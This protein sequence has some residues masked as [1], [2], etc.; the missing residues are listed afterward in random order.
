MERRSRMPPPDA[1]ATPSRARATVRGAREH[2]TEHVRVPL[3]RDGYALAL[4]SAFTAATGLLYWILAAQRY[5][6]HAV[7]INSA[8][9]SSMLFLAGIA[10]L[11][12]PNIL[13][14]FLPVAGDRT[15]RVVA[16]S[17]GV[18]ALIAGIAAVVFVLGVGA[19]APPLHFLKSDPWIRTA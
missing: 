4:N 9:I 7:G 16:W 1:A 19:W 6:A 15:T 5:S 17:Y 2:L 12:L 10:S 14:R 18:S 8:L 11:N 3:H 13:V